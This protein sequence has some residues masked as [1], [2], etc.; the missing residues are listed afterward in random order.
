M[1]GCEVIL[2]PQK[3]GGDQKSQENQHVPR[4]NKG[5]AGRPVVRVAG[6][7]RVVEGLW[8]L[9]G[10]EWKRRAGARLFGFGTCVPLRGFAC[11][12]S[13]GG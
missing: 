8:I 13:M 1:S 10:F 11:G 5:I 9:R 7:Y 4:W 12:D 2:L 6:I 3:R